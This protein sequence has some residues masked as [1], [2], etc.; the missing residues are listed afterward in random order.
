MLA[1]QWRASARYSRSLNAMRGGDAKVIQCPA[2]VCRPF[3]LDDWMKCSSLIK[4]LVTLHGALSVHGYSHP[5]DTR[6]ARRQTAE[7]PRRSENSRPTGCAFFSVMKDLFEEKD[8]L[9]RC[10]SSSQWP[11]VISNCSFCLLV[12]SS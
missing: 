11:S 6:D 12:P 8:L 5:V 9:S 2:F 10:R 7:T 1:H 4:N 3:T